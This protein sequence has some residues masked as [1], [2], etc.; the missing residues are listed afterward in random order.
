MVAERSIPGKSGV[1]SIS[2]ISLFSDSVN[3]VTVHSLIEPLGLDPSNAL[4]ILIILANPARSARNAN[5][6]S[7]CRRRVWIS[8]IGFLYL[9][10][11]KSLSSTISQTG[12]HVSERYL[13]KR[14]GRCRPLKIR[15]LPLEIRTSVWCLTDL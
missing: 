8:L 2:E 11:Y 13:R 15:P 5:F 7:G 9:S 3:P 6:Q 14:P 4:F 10:A 1:R 12:L